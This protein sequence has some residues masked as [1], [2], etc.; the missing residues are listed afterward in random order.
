MTFKISR[1]IGPLPAGVS[2][3]QR[4]PGYFGATTRAAVIVTVALLAL[5]SCGGSSNSVPA[6]T[7]LAPLTAEEAATIALPYLE[8]FAMSTAG[9]FDR[10]NALAFIGSVAHDYYLHQRYLAWAGGGFG[11][12][13]EVRREGAVIKLCNRQTAFDDT[14]AS[15]TKYSNFALSGDRTKVNSFDIQ[16]EPAQDRLSTG[17]VEMCRTGDNSCSPKGDSLNLE[18][19]TLYLTA[20]DTLALTYKFQRGK[21]WTDDMRVKSVVIIKND[22]SKV[23]SD[24]FSKGMPNKGMSKF[25][26]AFFSGL[27]NAFKNDVLKGEVVIGYPSYSNSFKM[28]FTL[29]P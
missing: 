5:S 13:S 25:G 15:Y 16:D 7:T 11:T 18:I 20:D 10:M 28:S 29:R 6:T 14:C 8:N 12:A 26:Y 24:D 2:V 27:R 4:A 19:L 21:K 3:S 17:D 22:G 23:S 1:K 9:G